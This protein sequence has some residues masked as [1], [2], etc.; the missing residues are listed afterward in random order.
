MD[1]N[2]KIFFLHFYLAVGLIGILTSGCGQDVP[3]ANDSTATAVALCK[4]YYKQCIDPIFYKSLT[5]TDG[6][7]KQCAECH[8]GG[9]GKSF[10]LSTADPSTNEYWQGSY[11]TAHDMALDGVNS[12]LL[13][14]PLGQ[15]AHGGGQFFVNTADADYSLIKI[16]LDNPDPLNAGG[17]FVPANDTAYCRAVLLANPC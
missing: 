2:E 1:A 8:R 9:P 6:A 15:L 14:K 13:L 17:D 12:K 4:S 11:Q 16:W 7:I 5:R 10:Q 3:V